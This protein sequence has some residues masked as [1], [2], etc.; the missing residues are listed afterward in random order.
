[1]KIDDDQTLGKKLLNGVP[2]SLVDGAGN[3][4]AVNNN[5]QP[6]SS[7]AN[8][9][10][11]GSMQSKEFYANNGFKNR[12]QQ[13]CVGAGNRDESITQ[14]ANQYHQ[15]EFLSS[16][17]HRPSTIDDFV[18]VRIRRTPIVGT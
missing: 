17:G 2:Q 7:T 12:G 15:P 13:N 10:E 18:N 16:F 5:S 3:S 11:M 8:T 9:A 4:V 1:M 14:N 6:S